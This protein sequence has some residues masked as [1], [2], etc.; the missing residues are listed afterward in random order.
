MIVP[1]MPEF[2]SHARSQ[3]PAP[4]RPPLCH[5]AR[6]SSTGRGAA[7]LSPTRG[8][9]DPR[10]RPSLSPPRGPGSPG[11][12]SEITRISSTPDLANPLQ[13]PLPAGLAHLSTPRPSPAG[14]VIRLPVPLSGSHGRVIRSCAGSPPAPPPLP[15]RSSRGRGLGRAGALPFCG[16]SFCFLNGIL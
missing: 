6:E 9:R 16:L 13:S 4:L 8:R 3:V 10:A 14:S 11:G 7:T 12:R 2:P 15:G 5:P 1:L